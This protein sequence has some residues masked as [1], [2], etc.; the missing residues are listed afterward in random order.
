MKR[1]S[2]TYRVVLL[3]FC[4][5]PQELLLFLPIVPGSDTGNDENSQ[6]NGKTFN[7]SYNIEK[8]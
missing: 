3:A 4:L 2:G 8:C 5:E 7:P 6:E 1:E